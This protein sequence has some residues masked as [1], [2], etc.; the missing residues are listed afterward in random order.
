MG[1]FCF[2]GKKKENRHGNNVVTYGD[3]GPQGHQPKPK[4]H[5]STVLNVHSSGGGGGGH[6]GGVGGGCGGGVGGGCGG[7]GG[8]CGGGGGGC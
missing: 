6:G 5:K 4:K 7:G 3:G 2:G 8:G 1:C